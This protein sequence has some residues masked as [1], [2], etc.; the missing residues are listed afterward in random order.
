MA[1]MQLNVGDNLN[2]LANTTS[3]GDISNALQNLQYQP[4]KS[5]WEYWQQW[6]Y[7]YV[8]KESYPVYIQERA[9]D[10]GQKAFEI[11]KMLKDKKLIDL[12]TVADFIEAMDALIKTL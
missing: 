12:K 2:L 11:I 7:P 5:C 10:K 8:I 4:T 9:M 1:M 6:Y 3:A